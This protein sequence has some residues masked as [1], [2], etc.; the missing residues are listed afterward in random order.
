M[1]P[2]ERRGTC[3]AKEVGFSG[4]GCFWG[5]G[6]LCAQQPVHHRQTSL[7]FW[8]ESSLVLDKENKMPVL[9]G[10]AVPEFQTGRRR[11]LEVPWDGCLQ[12]QWHFLLAR[13][14]LCSPQP[15]TLREDSPQESAEIS[16]LYSSPFLLADRTCSEWFLPY[17]KFSSILSRNCCSETG[18]W[19]S[20]W[21]GDSVA[22]PGTAIS[23]RWGLL[24]CMAGSGEERL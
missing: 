10:A 5:E 20:C 12:F 16:W 23:R 3:L 22:V 17:S 2:S 9:G 18:P 14:F 13:I 24:L 19:L 15:S 11:L 4:E 21:I 7:I 1:S 6:A 8:E